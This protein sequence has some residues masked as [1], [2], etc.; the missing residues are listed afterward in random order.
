[1]SADNAS[2]ISLRVAVANQAIGEW[3][4]WAAYESAVSARVASACQQGAR[5]LVFPEYGSMELASLF[6]A[7]VQQD[8]ALQLDALQS[9]RD[10]FVALYARLASASDV[11]ILAPSFPWREQ[12]GRYV[13]R[14]WVL[15]PA[16]VAGWQD[17]QQMTRFER[18]QWGISPGV[19][20]SVFTMDDM[21]VGVCLCYDI[22]FPMLARRLVEQGAQLLLAPSCTDT[23]AGYHRVRIGAQARA[24]ENQCYVAQ[25][26][27]VG[28]AAWSPAVD[29]NTGRAA[30]Y[31]P[32]DRGFPDDGVIA[33]AMDESPGW[34]VADLSATALERVRADGQVLNHRDW[35]RQ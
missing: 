27:T 9:L 24:L 16:G 35:S 2:V 34:V 31:G 26:C 17:K 20:Q 19:G 11:W 12:D 3:A 5:L 8:L 13:N 6:E 33:Q 14:A 22:E 7:E 29:V 25:A 28:E 18:E 15:S 4:D 23:L 10:R 21:Q 1:M 32:V 30:V